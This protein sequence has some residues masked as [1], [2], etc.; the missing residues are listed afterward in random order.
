MTTLSHLLR[1]YHRH[2]PRATQWAGRGAARTGP[3]GA[4]Y[5][6]D[7]AAATAPG[8]TMR[9][10]AV[11]SAPGPS[12]DGAGGFLTGHVAFYAGRQARTARLGLGMLRGPHAVSA[13]ALHPTGILS[14]PRCDC[15]GGRH[16]GIGAEGSSQA[17]RRHPGRM[18]G[19]HSGRRRSLARRIAGRATSHSAG[20]SRCV[21]GE[22][23]LTGPSALRGGGFSRGTVSA[24]FRHAGVCDSDGP[25]ASRCGRTARRSH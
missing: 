10:G 22:G 20:A 8:R 7:H 4:P 1:C 21:R 12:G 14:A 18:Y 23:R 15:V 6:A 17:F 13:G 9:P 25:G 16:T 3:S 11:P 24:Q 5:R 19:R 2:R